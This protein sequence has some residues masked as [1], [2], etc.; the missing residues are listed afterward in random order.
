MASRLE[1]QNELESLLGSDK[2]YFQPP[3]SLRMTYPCIRYE[4]R[5]P[6]QF[7]ASNKNYVIYRSYT[8]T[9]IYKNPDGDL[10]NQFL[11]TFPMCDH[12]RH[13]TG[14]GLHHDVYTIYF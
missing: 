12:D 8:V 14:D 10:V 2:V 3:E 5:G 13:Y 9:H 7:R 6:T 11:T 4:F 1:L